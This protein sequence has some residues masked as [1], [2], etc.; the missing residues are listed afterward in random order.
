MLENGELFALTTRIVVSYLGGN[1]TAIDEVPELIKTVA[2][3][4][5]SVQQ[6]GQIAEPG[7]TLVP[8]IPMRKSVRADS[9]ICLDCG[10][11]LKMLRRHLAADHGMT[12]DEYR[13]RW[14]LPPEYPMVAPEYAQTRSKLA[15]QLGL[16]QK[17]SRA[18]ELV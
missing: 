1:R 16:G 9:I 6:A 13:A 5:V 14:S 15:K 11:S 2:A 10:Q 4:L 8:A 17:R 7:P 12:A 18:K 3:S